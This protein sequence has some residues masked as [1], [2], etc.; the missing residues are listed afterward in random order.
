MYS[1]ERALSQVRQEGVDKKQPLKL[2]VYIL[3]SPKAQTIHRGVS[4]TPKLRAAQICVLRM[5]HSDHPQKALE[6]VP[7]PVA[8]TP[9]ASLLNSLASIVH[10]E[11]S[12]KRHASS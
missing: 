5:V 6:S 9:V 12:I 3:P 10:D 7:P 4:R 8:E 1:D 2:T 11:G